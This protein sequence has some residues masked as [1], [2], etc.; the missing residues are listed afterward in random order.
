MPDNEYDV[1]VLGAGFGGCACAALLAK[2][3]LKVLLV[4]KNSV[5]GGKA[6]TVS[7]RGYAHEMW[8]V[9]SAPA[10]GNL[11]E[12][13]LRECG[14]LDRVQLVH[15]E[16]QG[17][18]YI[19]P[20]GELRRLPYAKVPDP[21]KIFDVLGVRDDERPEAM[22]V[23]TDLALMSQQQVSEL[24][25]I[26]FQQW[27]DRY[28]VPQG[29]RTFLGAINNGV[30]M[31]PDDTLAASEGIRTVQ[32]I[33]MRGGGLYAKGGVGAVA[34]ALADSVEERGGTV[35]LRTRVRRI[36][37]EGGRAAGIE[38]DRGTFRAPV[39]VSN[40]GLQ[41]TVLKLVGAEHFDPAYVAYVKDLKPS[42]GMMGIRYFLDDI[43][44][45]EPYGMIFSDDGYW[46]QERWERAQDGDVPENI[47]VWFKV[48]ALFDPDMAPPGKQCVV[49]GA[50]CPADPDMTADQKQLWWDKVDEMMARVFPDL[51]AH[52]EDKEYYSTRHVS[53]LARDSVLPGYGGECIG[54]GQVVGQCGSHKPAAESPLPGLFFVGTDAGGYGCGAHHALNSGMNVARLVLERN[55]PRQ[56]PA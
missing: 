49:T 16:R 29:L 15:T 20:S 53:N 30:F 17:S 44:V 51:P 50:W 43:V 34:R 48:P 36:I 13:V 6:M 24:D 45:G 9:I 10:A 47:I 7:K 31:V 33:F 56:R 28:T 39:V 5:P 46:T 32:E 21:N 52:I 41:P 3:G 23:L 54:L 18:T 11:Y 2:D 38:T 12:A 19:S 40:A 27:L 4:D 25:G 1:I 42:L 8:P 22:R 55:R 37:V 26:S 14:V 35:L